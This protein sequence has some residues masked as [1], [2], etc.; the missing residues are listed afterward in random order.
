MAKYIRLPLRMLRDDRIYDSK[1]EYDE[2]L[3]KGFHYL[4]E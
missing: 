4:P 3:N 1:K 2:R